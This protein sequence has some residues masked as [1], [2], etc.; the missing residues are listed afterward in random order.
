MAVGMEPAGIKDTE[1]LG[2][3]PGVDNQMWKVRER[4]GEA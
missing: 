4:E 1:E 3:V 2:M